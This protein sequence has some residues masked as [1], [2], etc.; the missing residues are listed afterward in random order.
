MDN[1]RSFIKKSSL[2]LA[3]LTLPTAGITACASAIPA[4]PFAPRKP[5]KALVFWYS[6]TGNTAR[7][8]KVIARELERRGLMVDSGEYREI[9]RDSVGRYDF[10]VAGS[11][12]YYYDVPEN[13]QTWLG[14]LPD[15]KDIPV[16]SYVTFGGEG[17]NF[18]NTACTLLERLHARGGIPVG[19]NAFGNMSAFAPTWSYG[20]VKRVLKFKHK[21]DQESFAA[22]RK[23]A[24]TIL[25]RVQAGQS[26][27]VDRECNFREMIKS[28]PSIWGTKLLIDRHTIDKDRC[29][30]CGTCLEK[31]PV[32]AIDLNAYQVDRDRC[33][34]CMGCVNNC[35]AGAVDMVFMGKKVYGYY[36]FLKRNNI[37]VADPV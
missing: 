7:T 6:Q 28:K 22:M 2:S 16:A 18:H 20:N 11:P 9:D 3:A 19:W 26:V 37:T 5:E 12:V 23:F 17:G 1:R 32:G 4:E 13:F 8:G 21:P 35:P 34:L 10:V 36:E 27:D 31:C 29:V 15:I 14:T 33:L 25:T 24:S 30:G